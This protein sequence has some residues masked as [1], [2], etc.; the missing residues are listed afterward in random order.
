MNLIQI[1]LDLKSIHE[2]S[3]NFQK[4]TVRNP[5]LDTCGNPLTRNLKGMG[6]RGFQA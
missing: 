4:K 1:E 6:G 5:Y 2:I 3:F